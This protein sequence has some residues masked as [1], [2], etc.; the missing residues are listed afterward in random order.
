LEKI[1]EN[2]G[3]GAGLASLAFWG[4]VA[5]AV[6]ASVWENIRKRDAQHE[7]VRRMIESGQP[8]NREL[9]D[10]LV[11]VS[12][13]GR[14]RLDRDFK[15]VAL[16]TVPGAVGMAAFGWI[17]GGQYPQTEAPLLGVAALLG[18]VGIGFWLASKM[19]AH[20]YTDDDSSMNQL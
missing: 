2:I 4:F 18:C 17:M 15:L 8:L 6:V 20:W 19:V 7:T 10:K 13:G 5:T 9:L 16:Y 11:I 3:L 1:V 14:R 12:S